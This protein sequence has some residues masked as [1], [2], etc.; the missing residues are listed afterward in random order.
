MNQTDLQNF[1]NDSTGLPRTITL[2][3]EAGLRT[4]L[5]HL[6]PGEQIPEHQTRGAISVQCLKGETTF[7]SG[8]EQVVLK[9]GSLIALPPAAPHSLIAQQETLL[10]IT[11]SE[12]APSVSA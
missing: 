5:L 6:K 1:F 9:A 3:R 10:L 2:F 11:V 7:S 12:Q 4:L 8:S